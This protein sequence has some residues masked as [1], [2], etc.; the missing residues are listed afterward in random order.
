[1]RDDILAERRSGRRLCPTCGRS[2]NIHGVDRDGYF[3]P[4]RLP[5]LK[6]DKN[7]KQEVANFDPDAHAD[8][9]KCPYDG[10]PLIRRP[11]DD[12]K[13][14]NSRME[15]YHKGQLMCV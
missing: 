5:F 3:L 4:A 15:T 14:A 6:T 8:D 2:W 12:P 1:M 9:L 10:T 7:Y 13:I 11:D